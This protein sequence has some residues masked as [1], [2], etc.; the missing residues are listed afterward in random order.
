MCKFMYTTCM[1]GACA[2]QK[3]TSDSLE[4]EF[5]VVLTWAIGTERGSFAGTADALDH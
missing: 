2:D 3:R 1:S 4:L 5:Q